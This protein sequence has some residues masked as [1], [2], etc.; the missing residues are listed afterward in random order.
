MKIKVKNNVSI[1]EAEKA[2]TNNVALN[3]KRIG[4]STFLFAAPV[5]AYLFTTLSV[6]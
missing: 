3:A 6:W 5:I 4:I 1:S 2:N